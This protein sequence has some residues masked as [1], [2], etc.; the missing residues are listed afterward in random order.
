MEQT[1]EELLGKLNGIKR[2]IEAINGLQKKVYETGRALKAHQPSLADPKY[3]RNQRLYFT[4]LL[5]GA[6]SAIL[7]VCEA[8]LIGQ[9]GAAVLILVF[10]GFVIFNI[11]K[12]RKERSKFRRVL[13]VLLIICLIPYNI[14][15][16]VG[17][18]VALA[19]SFLLI[20]LSEKIV[21]QKNAEIDRQNDGVLSRMNEIQAQMA[22][23]VDQAKRIG[24]TWFPVDYYCMDA[25]DFF[26]SAVANQR[27]DNVKEL[28]NLYEDKRHKDRLEEKLKEIKGIAEQSVREQKMLQYQMTFSNIMQMQQLWTMQDIGNN[29]NKWYYYDSRRW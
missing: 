27:A 19:G 4:V 29:I 12:K 28:V 10:Y 11:Y 24:G 5:G 23:H 15:S 17:S 3:S 21:A 2:E 20:K 16:L 1:R 18:L 13:E 26:I 22:P 7:A 6:L 14:P 9:T 8:F 25:V